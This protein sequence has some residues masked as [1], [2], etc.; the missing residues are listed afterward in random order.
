MN[1]SAKVAYINKDL[2]EVTM[3]FICKMPLSCSDDKT[4]IA[5]RDLSNG[6]KY[7]RTFFQPNNLKIHKS[8]VSH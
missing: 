1:S 5:S 8:S 7:S 6:N 4:G 2:E 3:R